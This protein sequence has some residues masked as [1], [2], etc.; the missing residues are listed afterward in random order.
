MIIWVVCCSKKLTVGKFTPYSMSLR[1]KGNVRYFPFYP[2]SA[3]RYTHTYIYTNEIR[4]FG[5]SN[6]SAYPV[7]T[8]DRFAP[9]NGFQPGER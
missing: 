4:V 8:V 7:V 1:F 9:P 2:I 3:D 6:L 5:S